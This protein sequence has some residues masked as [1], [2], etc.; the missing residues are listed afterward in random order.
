M[1]K[2]EMYYIL[3]ECAKMKEVEREHTKRSG[4]AENTEEYSQRKHD[5]TVYCMA[6]DDVEYM[7]R[8]FIKY[9]S[10]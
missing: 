4:L 5:E 1:T 3:K 10:D 9:C 6:I 7:L 8:G 2:A